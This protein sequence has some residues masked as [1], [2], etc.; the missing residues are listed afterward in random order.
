VCVLSSQSCWAQSANTV[1]GS[2][3]GTA[4]SDLFSLYDPFGLYYDQPNNRIIV[5]DLGNGRAT[6]FSLANPSSGGTILAGGS[7]FGCNLNQ[8]FNP[9]G[10]VLDS[11]GQL[12]V[13]DTACRRVL[14]FPPNSN[15]SSFGVLV[16]NITDVE[17]LA[18]NPLTGDLYAAGYVNNAIYLFAQNSTTCATVAGT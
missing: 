7:S 14:K 4:G 1:A 16:A 10:V 13:S 5:A 12:Y 2:S 9:A 3:A 18:I 17:G 11:Y 15:S 8:L 6:Q